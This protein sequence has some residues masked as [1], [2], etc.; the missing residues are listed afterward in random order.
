MSSVL[1]E[2][3][4]L[5]LVIRELQQENRMLKEQVN[6]LRQRLDSCY[7]FI[8]NTGNSEY[9]GQDWDGVMGTR[10]VT[11]GNSERL[12]HLTKKFGIDEYPLE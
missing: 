5:N 11:T 1:K 3:H 12:D 9:A 10:S 2:L 4:Q 7:A 8:H 6:D